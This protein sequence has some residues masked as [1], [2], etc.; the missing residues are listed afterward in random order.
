VEHRNRGLERVQAFAQH[1]GPVELARQGR[2]ERGRGLLRLSSA[3][4]RGHQLS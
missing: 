2:V 3:G 1:V 4:L